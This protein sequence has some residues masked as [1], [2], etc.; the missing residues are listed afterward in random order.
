M[1]GRRACSSWY[2]LIG[3]LV[4][5]L[6]LLDLAS[7]G[8]PGEVGAGAESCEG[9]EAVGAG[10]WTGFFARA[11]EVTRTVNTKENVAAACLCG[12]LHITFPSKLI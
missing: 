1:A 8:S 2:R 11:V 6:D 7:T 12:E 9:A 10:G 4:V 5:A 3:L